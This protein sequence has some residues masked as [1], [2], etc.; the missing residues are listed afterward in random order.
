MQ[1]ILAILLLF[2][3]FSAQEW[4]RGKKKNQQNASDEEDPVA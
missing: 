3:L 2:A 1:L 4:M